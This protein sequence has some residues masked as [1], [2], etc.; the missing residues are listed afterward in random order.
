MHAVRDDPPYFGCEGDYGKEIFC[1][2][3]FCRLRQ[4]LG[5]IKGKFILSL[6]DRP[7]VRELYRDFR[8][9]KVKTSYS[10]SST[11]AKTGISEVLIMNYDQPK[12]KRG[13]TQSSG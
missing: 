13:L 5:E 2:E 3:D 8:I 1:R 6:N 4:I 7:E 11:G 10:A 12:T 9:M